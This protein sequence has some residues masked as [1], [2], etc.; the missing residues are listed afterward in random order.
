MNMMRDEDSSTKSLVVFFFQAED[1][2][3]DGHVTGVQT[4][5]LPISRPRGS[6]RRLD[7]PDPFAA[8]DLVEVACEL[9][10]AVTDHEPRLDAF[11]I[12]VHQQVTRLLGHPPAVGIRRDPCQMD[13]TSRQLHEEQDVE[14]LE[15]DG[16][17]G[18][19]VALE[20]AR[21]LLPK[22][23]RPTRLRPPRGRL[24]PCLAQD[25]P[26]R[27]R[28]ELNAEP[29]QFA[30]DPSVPPARVLARKPNDKLADLGRRR[31]SAGP[32]TRIGPM[33]LQKLPMPAQKRRR[34]HEERGPRP[35]WQDPTECSQ[36]RSVS[37]IQLR[38]RD[39]TL[40][41]PQLVA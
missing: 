28:R 32:P 22:E 39:L 17:D 31:G 4:C 33:P 29:H 15:E 1:G 10:V 40:E 12:E 11:V 3:R 26:D 8:E 25:R 21:R 6:Y 37:R 36:Q 9:A 38:T 16:V 2:I 13:A 7:H 30:L 41:H 18:E 27:A 35:P 5:A 34:R 14:P 23:L 20:N 19:E 24:D